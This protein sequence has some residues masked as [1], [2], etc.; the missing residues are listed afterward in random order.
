VKIGPFLRLGVL[1]GDLTMPIYEYLSESPDDPDSSCRI[2]A[3]GFELRRPIDREALEKCPLCKNPVRKV[4]SRIN[5]PK[6]TKP[7][8][9]STAKAAGFQVLEK[10]CDGSYEKM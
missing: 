8:S 6:V 9:T 5:T 2:C 3:K 4:I 7:L 10:R 1:P